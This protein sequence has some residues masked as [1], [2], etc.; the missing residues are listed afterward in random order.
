MLKPGINKYISSKSIA[1]FRK[2]T[3]FG[4]DIYYIYLL[5]VK[6]QMSKI[7]IQQANQDIIKGGKKPL[8]D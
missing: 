6:Q 8:S 2:K 4:Y 5:V 7:K 3:T 1:P